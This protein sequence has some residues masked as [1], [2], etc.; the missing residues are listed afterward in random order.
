[1]IHSPAG[2]PPRN[3]RR[4][5]RSLAFGESINIP[6]QSGLW[7]GV[8]GLPATV[9]NLV[10]FGLFLMV[11]VEG[12]GYW[13]AKLHQIRTRRRD[14]PGTAVFRVARI[15]NAPLLA[16]GVAV[17][18]YAVVT[19]PGWSSVPGLGF[20]AFAVLEHVNYFHVQLAHGTATDL[21]RLRSVGLRRSHLARDLHRH[22]HPR[23]RQIRQRQRPRS[24]ILLKMLVRL[25]VNP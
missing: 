14:L 8:I 20:A 21:R 5:L 2:Q 15:A 12:T 6:L 4:R 23:R 11:L 18:G 19:A 10:G 3:I 22:R 9:A 17:T 1:M 7:F 25:R 24:R 13:A 16:V